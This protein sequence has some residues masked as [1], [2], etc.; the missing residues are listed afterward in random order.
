MNKGKKLCT[1]GRGDGEESKS[2]LRGSCASERTSEREAM[3][4]ICRVPMKGRIY[5][6]VGEGEARTGRSRFI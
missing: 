3:N 2:A 4:K 6:D 1:D 5:G